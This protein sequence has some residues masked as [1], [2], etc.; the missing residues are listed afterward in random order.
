MQ[1]PSYKSYLSGLH[2]LGLWAGSLH[3]L[4][5][6]LEDG[7]GP[8]HG[9]APLEVHQ[10]IDPIPSDTERKSQSNQLKNRLSELNHVM[11]SLYFKYHSQ[12][13]KGKG[14]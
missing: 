8:G 13:K 5:A 10:G 11:Y 7:Q 12:Y 2:L 6:L 9:E 14:Q 4:H 3:C 1:P